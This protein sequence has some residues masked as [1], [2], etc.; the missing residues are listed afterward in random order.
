MANNVRISQLNNDPTIQ[1]SDFFPLVQS[2]SMTTY[3]AT[4]QSVD[5]WFSLSG[6]VLN[7]THSLSSSY[8]ETASVSLI[9]LTASYVNITS[10]PSSSYAL[11]SSYARTAS[12]AD[13]ASYFNFT[14]SSS[15]PPFAYNALSASWAS[16]SLTTISASY[17][18]STLSSSYAKTA[19]FLKGTAT[20]SNINSVSFFG[21]SSQAITASYVLGAS[22]QSI[23]PYIYKLGFTSSHD[24]HLNVNLL[25]TTWQ[26]P[27]F[28]MCVN[29]T[30]AGSLTA[31]LLIFGDTSR[32]YEWRLTASHIVQQY[33]SASPL[34]SML[35]WV[36]NRGGGSHNWYF[37]GTVDV[38]VATSAT[39]TVTHKYTVNTGLNYATT[40]MCVNALRIAAGLNGILNQDSLD[41]GGAVN[42]FSTFASS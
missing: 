7:A 26:A 34:R 39:T 20:G 10:N 36:D 13:T 9:A 27:G 5:N 35:M 3:R 4:I 19:S 18:L 32:L 28:G 21:T 42:V 24:D 14:L 22:A 38:V 16:A 40:P 37:T 17:A 6:S 2:G 41:L 15:T 31:Y 29:Q 8:A 23:Y 11:S 30:N 25:G 12:R 1:P 33:I